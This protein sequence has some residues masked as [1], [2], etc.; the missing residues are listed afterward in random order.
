MP[1]LPEV[2][3]IRRDLEKEI[4]QT[5]ITGIDCN[6]ERMVFPSVDFI[7]RVAVGKEILSVKR[8]GK[9]LLIDLKDSDYHLFVHLKMTGRL[10]V[11]SNDE[12]SDPYTRIRITLVDITGNNKE[13]RFSDARKFGYIRAVHRKQIGEEF[14]NFGPEPFNGLTER[15]LREI[16]RS[17]KRPIKTLLLDQRKIAGIGNIYANEALFTAGI[18][19]NTL[20]KKLSDTEIKGLFKAI[21]SVLTEGIEKRGASDNT[22]RDIYGEKGSYQNYYRVYRRVGEKC[23]RCGTNIKRVVIAGRGTFVCPNCQMSEGVKK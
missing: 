15:V 3:T 10:F 11:K 21:E 23:R 13:I 20:S 5:K 9:L 19:P 6:T 16:V 14:A 8:R 1:E 18:S 12:F 4:C 17:S 7:R 2:E 22:Y